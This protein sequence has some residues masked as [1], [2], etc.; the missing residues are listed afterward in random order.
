MQRDLSAGPAGHLNQLAPEVRSDIFATGR[1]TL[2]R[3]NVA[4]EGGSEGARW[5]GE[6]EGNY[7]TG[8]IYGPSTVQTNV[9]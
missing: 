4:K 6:S 8:Y 7:W 1:N 2:Q 9:N 5:N 3:Q